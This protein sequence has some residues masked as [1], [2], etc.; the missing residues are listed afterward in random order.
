[1]SADDR[2]QG[3]GP[4]APQ[5][6]DQPAA[7]QAVP[8]R[9]PSG[10]P[11]YGA[12]GHPAL[13]HFLP[14][15]PVSEGG[16]A[17]SGGLARGQPRS[18]AQPAPAA[19][20]P[21]QPAQPPPAS[22][23]PPPGYPGGPYPGPPGYP[24][25]PYPGPPGY[26]G[27]PYP[28]QGF[29]GPVASGPPS[30]EGRSA[31]PAGPAPGALKR[32]PALEIVLTVVTVLALVGVGVGVVLT[33]Q[34][35]DERSNRVAQL[36]A[37]KAGQL[38]TETD[39]ETRRRSELTELD[40]FGK[41]AALETKNQERDASLLNWARRGEKTN[42]MYLVQDSENACMAAILQ[43]NYFAA[44]YA[45]ILP[46]GLPPKIDSGDPNYNCGVYDLGPAS[47]DT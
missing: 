44:K 36:K 33:G 24:G 14:T 17:A 2:T 25:G 7:E 37:R 40:L 26:P 32:P 43:Y 45:D 38:K 42:E 18:A 9:P 47:T 22:A 16:S 10:Q 15:Q 41:L 20:Q 28:G 12:P 19:A 35:V 4:Q 8:A 3:H 1:M 31:A 5:P 6:T 29:R 23:Q 27:G 21:A 30:G 39:E 13:A 46:V 34:G 11:G